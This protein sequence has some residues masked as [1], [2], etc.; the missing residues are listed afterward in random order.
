M[1]RNRDHMAYHNIPQALEGEKSPY[2]LATCSTI[3][4]L[5]KERQQERQ[6]HMQRNVASQ[7]HRQN[8]LKN[9][10]AAQQVQGGTT[11]E[12]RTYR[13]QKS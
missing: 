7:P 12:R 11:A 1:W 2:K 9:A 4:N 6:R 10:R 5:E 13:F 3:T 8:L